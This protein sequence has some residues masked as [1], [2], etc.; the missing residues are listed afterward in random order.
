MSGSRHD[1]LEPGAHRV[2]PGVHRISLPLPNDGLRAV[3]VYA[4]EDGDRLVLIDAGWALPESRDRLRSG[5]AHIGAALSDI[6]R[7]LVT[8][9]HRDHYTQ[10]VAL[11]RE[12]G[13]RVSLGRGE[14]ANIR[15]LCRPDRVPLAKQEELLGFCGA[16]PVRDALVA[17]REPVSRQHLWE[18][19]DDW[20][21]APGE[22][23]LVDRRLRAVPTP[24]H[25]QGHLVFLDQENGLL[26]AG[27]H[28]LPHITPS[29]GFAQEPGDA[30]LR[31]YQRSLQLVH[32]LPDARLLPAHGPVTDSV[33]Q[34]VAELLEHH[35]NR[36][37][38]TETAVRGGAATAYE[39][40]RALPWTRRGRPFSDLDVFN[41]ML[42]V[43]ETAAHLDVLVLRN[44]LRK[45]TAD[46]V[47]RYVLP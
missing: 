33:H 38:E 24:G 40:A 42:A 1:W 8:H 11:R 2:A 30:P 34:R 32:Q 35:E 29:I 16:K 23:E 18:E 36:L 46:D 17:T 28:V 3:N 44:R 14:Q 7:V 12:F 20:I 47:V 43:L 19:P 22:I 41:Q 9:A 21:A 26:F 45:E 5:L 37:A 15:G 10:A 39:A 31:D 6:S 27:D 4:I 25:T 13:V